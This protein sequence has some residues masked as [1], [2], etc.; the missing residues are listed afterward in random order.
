MGNNSALDRPRGNLAIKVEGIR[1]GVGEVVV[2]SGAPEYV[3]MRVSNHAYE[4]VSQLVECSAILVTRNRTLLKRLL[5]N[6]LAV[7]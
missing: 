5:A 2:P 4:S 6:I 7:L 3:E 1:E